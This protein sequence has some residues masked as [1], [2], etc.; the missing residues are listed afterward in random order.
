MLKFVFY[1]IFFM[2][3]FSVLESFPDKMTAY[4]SGSFSQTMDVIFQSAEKGLGVLAFASI[5]LVYAA[6]RFRAFIIVSIL[7]GIVS[8]VLL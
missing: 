4:Q 3:F 7:F 6:N 1:M 8:A 5:G 2:F